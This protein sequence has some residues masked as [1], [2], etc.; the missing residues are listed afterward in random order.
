MWCFPRLHIGSIALFIVNQW[1]YKSFI[2]LFLNIVCRW[3]QYV[4]HGKYYDVLCNRINEDLQ[5]IKELLH[6]NKLSL[7]V[8]KTHYMIFFPRSKIAQ[9]NDIKIY[10]TRIQRL[11]VTKFLRVQIDDHLTWK[12][13][14]D[15][16]C[17][18]L[19][20]CVGILAK[21]RKKLS[22]SSQMKPVLFIAY[23]YLIYCNHVWG[24]N[25]TTSLAK[26]HLVQKKNLLDL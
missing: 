14:I 22:K 18:K 9:C 13:L 4:Q 16:T 25:F 3:H 15:Y 1:L 23:P 2:S 10:G 5:A 8:L 24:N 7:N 6:C 19:L 17:S 11:Y 26:L 20:K 12:N 21:A